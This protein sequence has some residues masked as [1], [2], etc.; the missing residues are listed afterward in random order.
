MTDYTGTDVNSSAGTAVTE[1]S[2]TSSA[3]TVAAGS[4]GD[5]GATPARAR[6]S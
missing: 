1:R 2:G 6:T 4:L 3:D 5:C